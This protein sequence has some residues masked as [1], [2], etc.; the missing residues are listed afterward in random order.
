M[1]SDS[2]LESLS[3]SD[4]E[5]AVM[6]EESSED[7]DVE[8]SDD[9]RSDDV[10]KVPD[11]PKVTSMAA[12]MAA[13][14]STKAAKGE[15]KLQKAVEHAET[16]KEREKEQKA[17]E[18]ERR[19]ALKVDVEQAKSDPQK[20]QDAAAKMVHSPSQQKTVAPQNERSVIEAEESEEESNES[21]SSDSSSEEDENSDAVEL[22]PA[23]AESARKRKG[24][25]RRL[26]SAS[27][28]ALAA[29]KSNQSDEES[30]DI[31]L[32][33]LAVGRRG[34]ALSR[35]R[36]NVPAKPTSEK[37]KSAG[38]KTN[39]Q[40]V[41]TGQNATTNGQGGEASGKRL[42]KPQA[43]GSRKL[44]GQ[45]DDEL[46]RTQF[47]T[48]PQISG[49]RTGPGGRSV[50][51]TRET[52]HGQQGKKSVAKR[53]G[54][55]G[56]EKS[57]TPSRKAAEGRKLQREEDGEK[58]GI[59][60]K[61][62]RRADEQRKKTEEEERSKKYEA[63]KR[64]EEEAKQRLKTV[65]HQKKKDKE[66]ERRRKEKEAQLKREDA[67]VQRKKEEEQR[68][69]KAED[70][71]KKK[72]EDQRKEKVDEQR[73]RKADEQRERKAD[74]QR[75][76][77]ED[78][79]QQKNAEKQRKQDE[80]ERLRKREGVERRKGVGEV[81]K[82][83]DVVDSE[84][85]RQEREGNIRKEENDTK[86]TEPVKQKRKQLQEQEGPNMLTLRRRTAEEQSTKGLEPETEDADHAT[87]RHQ[88]ASRIA[89]ED[90]ERRADN[91]ST[92]SVPIDQRDVRST[93]KEINAAVEQRQIQ[94][95]QEAA[96][97][98]RSLKK[99]K[100]TEGLERNASGRWTSRKA[101]KVDSLLGLVSEDAIDSTKA[102][103][104]ARII[105]ADV[106]E[107]QDFTF[108]APKAEPSARIIA[109]DVEEDQDFTFTAP[110]RASNG[111]A[112]P[113]PPTDRGHHDAMELSDRGDERDTSTA[114]IDPEG[115]TGGDSRGK[116]GTTKPSID[117]KQT[118]SQMLVS[119]QT[120]GVHPDMS[121]RLQ[122]LPNRD[123]HHD[124]ERVKE[125]NI[126][127]AKE[128][129]L[130][131]L[132]APEHEHAPSHV[133]TRE[134]DASGN[135]TEVDKHDLQFSQATPQ[136]QVLLRDQGAS[137]RQTRSRDYLIP[138]G[139]SLGSTPV[140]GDGTQAVEMTAR[141]PLFGPFSGEPTSQ[142]L[143]EHLP[144][145]PLPVMTDKDEPF[146][147]MMLCQ[148]L[149]RSFWDFAEAQDNMINGF[150]SL[151][152]RR[153]SFVRSRS[154]N[155]YQAMASAEERRYLRRQKW[156]AAVTSAQLELR[157]AQEQA[158]EDFAKK[159]SAARESHVNALGDFIMRN[160][161]GEVQAEIRNPL[162]DMPHDPSQHVVRMS[163]MESNA[164][165]ARDSYAPPNNS[166]RRA[167]IG[168]AGLG[169][170]NSMATANVVFDNGTPRGNVTFSM[171]TEV[172]PPTSPVA[173]M[174]PSY[175][176]PP[177]VS[178]AIA[179]QQTPHFVEF[180]SGQRV[181]NV[182]SEVA[183][184][185]RL[186]GSGASAMGVEPTDLN[187]TF[188]VEN[189]GFASAH[190]R[191]SS[192]QGPAT[193]ADVS[194]AHAMSQA[195]HHRQPQA[196]RSAA[197][198]KTTV[199]P[200]AGAHFS[201]N[202]QS[203]SGNAALF[204]STSAASPMTQFAGRI[205]GANAAAV[206]TAQTHDEISQDKRAAELA[207]GM[208]R[209][210]AAAVNGSAHQSVHG[211]GATSRRVSKRAKKAGAT[212]QRK[213]EAEALVK[214]ADNEAVRRWIG[215]AYEGLNM[216]C[217]RSQAILKM[218]NRAGGVAFSKLHELLPFGRKTLTG[219]LSLL[220]TKGYLNETRG[221]EE[222]RGKEK[223]FLVYT[224]S[225]T[226]AS[227]Q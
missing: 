87:V 95:T 72:A 51:A 89:T 177:A 28:K 82:K 148:E 70:Q 160:R 198:Q 6:G 166:L 111:P 163:P 58:K 5:E 13:A 7:E 195:L 81:G 11:Q 185:V 98:P 78:D 46:E 44:A 49:K 164:G 80:A 147:A 218:C 116:D 179:P 146:Q 17:Q 94:S 128:E 196:K 14:R 65:Q 133:L 211:T 224:T 103:P 210:A 150:L 165:M 32:T 64:G 99:R 105:A 100:H 131:H 43:P 67:E 132:S 77:Q 47:A 122:Q 62:A 170:A 33:S 180:S 140:P 110:V 158:L 27:A 66:D 35:K 136:G 209:A 31:P 175:G 34:A 145:T 69:M 203:A 118:Q 83:H 55:T 220:T 108:T 93:T 187:P 109:A 154:A 130:S 1:G 38:E 107:N 168:S 117:E 223:T 202:L 186:G 29:P 30:D 227:L 37:A 12:R 23:L 88:D 18:E 219:R 50:L 208:L 152:R 60:A 143:S 86:T 40:E 63:E 75:T 190:G 121:Q 200:S 192:L 225:N 212:V 184:G 176:T 36:Q 76:K 16:A 138:D 197:A 135:Q 85:K 189:A 119:A 188:L 213:N 21:S 173:Q 193:H 182:R 71:R 222:K 137:D 206:Q 217:Y 167:S 54:V 4:V 22:L 10:E 45:D 56:Q 91:K 114:P 84:R 113:V 97:P 191:R 172:P 104:S 25:P 19:K 112:I 42:Q 125:E 39:R 214:L 124:L 155:D 101:M 96:S 174:N 151:V 115:V 120:Q 144:Q 178:V 134:H 183:P 53:K 15:S 221:K 73:K 102:E 129:S 74:E 3:L 156:N 204:P 159:V 169:T 207:N 41:E 9:D 126:A 92:R 79:A 57:E 48:Q 215:K 2:D 20:T 26:V 199:S 153:S 194:Q 171:P 61:R 139:L 201:E 90:G 181:A 68:K 127:E 52:A 24:V 123:T 8:E 226:V 162:G 216:D 157:R 149:E 142:R 161:P 141:G 205:A 59:G 106:E